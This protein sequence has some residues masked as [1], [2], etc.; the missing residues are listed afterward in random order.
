MELSN[1][2]Q[3]TPS[4]TAVRDFCLIQL[5]K[6][7]VYIVTFVVYFLIKKNNRKS[8]LLITM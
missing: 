6:Q 1:N 5:V 8:L 4:L 3:I 2:K 7:K